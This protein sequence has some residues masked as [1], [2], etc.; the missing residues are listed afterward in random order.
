M[1][2]TTQQSANITYFNNKYRN[3]VFIDRD[4]QERFKLRF[5]KDHSVLTAELRTYQTLMMKKRKV[6][7]TVW[8][9]EAT[10]SLEP[11][12][13]SA[14]GRLTYDYIVEINQSVRR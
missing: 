5:V 13:E 11:K 6:S 10:K 4:T 2:K 9:N 14:V 8:D 7:L 1:Q 3:H 12:I